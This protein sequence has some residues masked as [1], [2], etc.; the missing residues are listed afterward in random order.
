MNRISW[1]IIWLLFVGMTIGQSQQRII[2]YGADLTS[3][4]KQTV[5]REFPL[6]TNV[7]L[8][9][10][11]ALTVTNKEEWQLLKGLVPEA[12]IGTKAVSS[13]FIEKR[14]SGTGLEIETKNLSLITPHM[15]A[16]ALATA[17]VK[18]A[19]V[20]AA[21]PT[22]VSGTAALTGIFKSFEELT[23]TTLTEDAKRVAVEE[24]IKTGNLGEEIGKERAATL[25]ERSKERVIREKTTDRTEIIKVVERSAREQNLTLTDTQKGDVAELLLKIKRL[26]IDLDNLQR[27]LK[28]FREA[29]D[30]TTTPEKPESFFS[31]LISFIRSLVDQLFSF[32]GRFFSIKN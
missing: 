20:V 19:K 17:G 18:D 31:R 26:N 7:K 5:S 2:S 25:L 28:N 13:V 8:S 12:E 23:G 15:I 11:K 6:P 21:A 9:E 4:E 30:E 22:L 29:P 16:N 24:L 10:I 1:F 14:D 32:V 27:Q 3:Q